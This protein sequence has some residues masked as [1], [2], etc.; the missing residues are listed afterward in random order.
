MCAGYL[1]KGN[2]TVTTPSFPLLLFHFV[3]SSMAKPENIQNW[4]YTPYPH[5]ASG[6]FSYYLHRIQATR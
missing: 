6:S 5:P 3:A 4:H 2:I 1:E